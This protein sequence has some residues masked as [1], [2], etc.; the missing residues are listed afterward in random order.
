MD[1]FQQYE[2]LYR[3]RFFVTKELTEDDVES[4]LFTQRYSLKW[5][6]R[7]KELRK[8]LLQWLDKLS[9]EERN[10]LIYA[11]AVYKMLQIL[12]NQMSLI[13]QASHIVRGSIHLQRT[14]DH[15][16]TREREALEKYPTNAD[17]LVKAIQKT[18]QEKVDPLQESYR[19]MFNSDLV[20]RLV[21]AAPTTVECGQVCPI[22][23]LD[24]SHNHG[25][26]KT[27]LSCGHVACQ[28]CLRQ[29]KRC[30]NCRQDIQFSIP[31]FESG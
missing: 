14:L 22:C 11:C 25:H 12:P 28:Q 8:R 16:A 15:F 6:L 2:Q 23:T 30:P 3:N 24:Y 21:L 13:Q 19:E 27:A 18:I 31:I 4:I 20:T 9:E 1:V 29:V 10:D 26:G 17:P 5:T 7:K